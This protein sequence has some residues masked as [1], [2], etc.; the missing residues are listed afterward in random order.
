MNAK[1]RALEV[2][3]VTTL[4]DF[5]VVYSLKYDLRSADCK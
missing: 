2:E 5:R 4:E 1:E 3:M